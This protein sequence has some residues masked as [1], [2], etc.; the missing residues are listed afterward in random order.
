MISTPEALQGPQTP[1][2]YDPVQ[3]AAEASAFADEARA[4]FVAPTLRLAERHLGAIRLSLAAGGAAVLG[5]AIAAAWVDHRLGLLLVGDAVAGALTLASAVQFVG[6]RFARAARSEAADAR[7]RVFED[8]LGLKR[9]V[10]AQQL[11]SLDNRECE[12]GLHELGRI[13][14]ATQALNRRLQ[15][16]RAEYAKANRKT[17]G[18][19][20]IGLCLL[21][22]AGAAAVALGF[23]AHDLE[24]DLAS[25]LGLLISGVQGFVMLRESRAHL[26]T[27]GDLLS[28]QGD[29]E[30]A[31][32]DPLAP[33]SLWIDE[34]LTQRNE[35]EAFFRRPAT[36]A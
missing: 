7:R 34:V 10:A 28:P 33:V 30:I 36:A 14:A 35:H 3:I 18:A 11:R 1:I 15:I 32:A 27:L 31:G 13:W 19:A 22:A 4:A 8:D 20:E 21:S 16:D 9:Q 25:A 2:L 12:A 24:S 29:A 6:A 5:S 26:A 23:D 17:L